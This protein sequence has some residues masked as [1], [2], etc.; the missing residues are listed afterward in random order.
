MLS[1][2]SYYS[3]KTCMSAREGHLTFFTIYPRP[4][5]HGIQIQISLIDLPTPLCSISW[6]FLLILSLGMAPTEFPPLSQGGNKR[7]IALSLL[8]PFDPCSTVVTQWP[9]KGQGSSMKNPYESQCITL[10]RTR[11]KV[12]SWDNHDFCSFLEAFVMW[13]N[14]GPC[15]WRSLKDVSWNPGSITAQYSKTSYTPRNTI[16][17]V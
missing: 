17:T 7:D 1:I 4:H 3:I 2:Y 13:D 11:K 10:F 6:Y 12:S 14:S 8:F 5:A 16:Y 15:N 9:H